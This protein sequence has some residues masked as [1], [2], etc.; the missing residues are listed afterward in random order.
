VDWAKHWNVPLTCNE[1]GVYRKDS[2]PQDR[3]RWLHDVRTT[4]EH[5]GIGWNMWDFGGRDNGMGF[6]VVNGPKAG[7]NTPD[8]VTLEALGLKK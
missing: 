5:D 8:E 3:S 6:G 7:P 1:F 2:D 4:L